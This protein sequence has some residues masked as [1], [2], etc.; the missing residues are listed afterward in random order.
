MPST[1]IFIDFI[2]E[3]I[4]KTRY[5]KIFY[6]LWYYNFNINYFCFVRKYLVFTFLELTHR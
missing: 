2:D 1:I 4:L 3:S 5:F 6:K